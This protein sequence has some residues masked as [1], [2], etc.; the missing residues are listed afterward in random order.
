MTICGGWFCVSGWWGF[1]VWLLGQ[2]LAKTLSW[3]YFVDVIIII[4]RCGVSR[5]DYPPWYG[6]VSSTQLKAWTANLR[7]P[8]KG[9]S[10]NAVR[11]KILPEFPARWPALQIPNSRLLPLLLPELPDCPTDFRLVSPH[12]CTS[13]VLKITINPNA[14]VCVCVCSELYF[15]E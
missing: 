11:L 8:R 9:I 4:R 5:S 15:D 1:G 14:C 13:Q 10:L 2:V 12:N 3:G 7:F 6:W